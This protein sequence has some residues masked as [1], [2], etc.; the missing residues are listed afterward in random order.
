MT[1]LKKMT[2]KKK[3]KETKTIIEEITQE[4][5]QLCQIELHACH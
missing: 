5:A 1:I 2:K 3:C 4:V